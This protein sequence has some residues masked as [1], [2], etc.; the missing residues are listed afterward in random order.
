MQFTMNLPKDAASMRSALTSVWGFKDVDVGTAAH[1]DCPGI[2]SP[3]CGKHSA[4]SWVL[5]KT[6][7]SAY[8][9]ETCIVFMNALQIG[10]YTCIRPV[11]RYP[12]AWRNTRGYHIDAWLVCCQDGT[13]LHSCL[14]AV[15]V[16]E[17][18][19]DIDEWQVCCL[20]GTVLHGYVVVILYVYWV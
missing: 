10:A 11:Q 13:E 1:I 6:N 17:R 19:C 20:D 15:G 12:L 5:L 9:W 7:K 16:L 4:S 8:I 18:G 14:L 2:Y 3:D